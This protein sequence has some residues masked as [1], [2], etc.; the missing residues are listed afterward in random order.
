MNSKGIKSDKAVFLRTY[1][2]AA[3]LIGYVTLIIGA[4]CAVIAILGVLQIVEDWGTLTRSWSTLV[5]TGL[6]S[7][8]VV[9]FTRY[10][11][12]DERQ[13]GILVKFGDKILYV[14]AVLVF[15][16]A[17]SMIIY[18]YSSGQYF[19]LFP[20]F[21]LNSAR[22]LVLIGIGRFVRLMYLQRAKRGK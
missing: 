13:A 12:D 11:F 18:F 8:G 15:L 2:V 10:L 14:F 22:I 3:Y 1:Y 17:L 20:L 6:L 4:I 16:R 19:V 21:F 5:L 7:I 9:Q